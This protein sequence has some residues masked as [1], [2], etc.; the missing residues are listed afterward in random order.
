M[1]E[2]DVLLVVTTMDTDYIR[3]PAT[4]PDEARRKSTVLAD[5]DDSQYKKPAMMGTQSAK[6]FVAAG[7]TTRSYPDTIHADAS[8]MGTSRTMDA[9]N[10]YASNESTR[11]VERQIIDLLQ[12]ER[13]AR[14]GI[15]LGLILASI[16]LTREYSLLQISAALMTVAIGL[17]LLYVTFVIQTQRIFSD[18]AEAVHPYSGVIGNKHELTTIDKRLVHHY[19]SIIVDVSE[20]IIR[21]LARIVFIEDSLTSLK[22]LMIFW[23]TWTI[24]AHVSSRAIVMFFVVSAF[25]FPRLYLSNKRVVDAHVHQGEAIIRNHFQTAQALVNDRIADTSARIRMFFAQMN[26]TPTDARNTLRNTSASLK[27]D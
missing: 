9:D 1:T 10:F 21:A 20:T 22:W 25:I 23:V 5:V 18:S 6:P 27:E 19:S 3:R 7:T 16:L 26:T 12:W 15:T 8:T 2:R 17:N 13:P 4:P 14:S 24:S 11:R